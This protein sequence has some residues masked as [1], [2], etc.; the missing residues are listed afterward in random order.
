M[1]VPMNESRLS[2]PFM[3]ILFPFANVHIK[4]TPSQYDVKT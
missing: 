2:K 1:P 4:V 3:V